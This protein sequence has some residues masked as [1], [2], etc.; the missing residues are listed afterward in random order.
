MRIGENTAEILVPPQGAR[1]LLLLTQL[2]A[3]L[4]PG[5][6]M[7]LEPTTAGTTNQSSTVELRP[8]FACVIPR[9]T[10]NAR[11]TNTA[12]AFQR[13]HYGNSRRAQAHIRAKKDG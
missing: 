8:P 12:A 1:C 4:Q 13:H 5:W 7:G 3:P 10:Q 9:H 11:L 2:F 6:S